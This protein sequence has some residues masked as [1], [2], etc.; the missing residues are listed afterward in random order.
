MEVIE[1]KEKYTYRDITVILRNCHEKAHVKCSKNNGM[2][3]V[4]SKC[5]SHG[6]SKTYRLEYIVG[7]IQY[8]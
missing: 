3:R 4:A 2:I 6:P 1:K 5:M 8:N 7:N